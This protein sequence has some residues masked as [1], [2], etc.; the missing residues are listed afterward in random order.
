ML[1][2]NGKYGGIADSKYSGVEGAFAES[3]GIDGHSTPGL[4]KVHQKLSLDSGATV[5]AF[6]KVALAASNGYTFWFSSTS[7]KIFARTPGGVWSLAYTTSP[8]SGGAGCLGKREFNGYIYWATQSYL[9]RIAI[10]DAD[11]SWANV[12]PNWD[13]FEVTD[14]LFHPMEEQDLSL[15]TGD[16]NQVHKVTASG[17]TNRN[18]LDIKTPHRI[19]ALKAYDIDL[20]L[21][22]F[23]H[24]RVQK[25][26]IVRWDTVDTSWQTSDEI[27]EAGINAFLMDENYVL[28]QAGLTGNWY[29]F[30]GEQLIPYKTIPGVYVDGNNATQSVKVHE[31]SVGKFLGRPIFGVSNVNGNAAKQGVYTFGSY[32]KDY[33]KVM[34][35]SWVISQNKT[36]SVETGAIIVSNFELLVAWKDGTNYGVDKIDWSNKYG[37]AYM[38]TMMLPDRNRIKVIGEAVGYY[39]TLKTSGI[40]FSARTN[41]GDWL[42]LTSITNSARNGVQAKLSIPKASAIQ[43]RINPLVS[44]NDGPEIEAIEVNFR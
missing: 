8:T 37:N 41:H 20:L 42:S 29:L 36:E 33:P 7:G 3:V 23:I 43:M 25:A 4:L 19:S 13:L 15:F 14:A 24:E 6:V 31:G 18:V 44:G 35:L 17:V 11:D 27:E 1:I 40:R 10:A 30:N 34:D 39:A 12:V 2:W 28:V 5:D 38:E 26:E 22:T 32:S 21:G 16:G 9:H